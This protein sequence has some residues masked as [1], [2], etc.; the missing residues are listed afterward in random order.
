MLLTAESSKA[1]GF[2]LIEVMVAMLVLSIGLMAMLQTLGYAISHNRSNKLRNDAILIADQAMM[3]D[4]AKPFSSISSA[5]TLTKVPFALGFVN[6]SV[7]EKVS[8][9][10]S[11]NPP[12]SKNVQFTVVWRDRSVRKHH[13][14]TTTI[15]N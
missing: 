1:N 12:T 6:Y 11:S 15:S 13:S 5:S 4:R 8:K 2:T 7:I 3:I 14:L 10:G 9:I